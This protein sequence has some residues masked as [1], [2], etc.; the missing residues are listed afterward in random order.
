MDVR[1]QAF[2]ESVTGFDYLVH[3]DLQALAKQFDERLIDGLQNGMVQKLEYTTEIGWK[4]LKEFLKAQAGVDEASP[5]KVVK[6]C[7]REEYLDEADYLLFLHAID[8][9]N[10]LSHVYSKKDFL[11]ILA[12][13]PGY[14]AMFKRIAQRLANDWSE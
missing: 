9:R 7:Y 2:S 11:E 13:L 6:A 3:V 12:R 14:A 10:R 1:L 5:K 8:D 4:T